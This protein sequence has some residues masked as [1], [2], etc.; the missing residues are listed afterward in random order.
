VL[1][2]EESSPYL[3]PKELKERKN[4]ALSGKQTKDKQ[5][6]RRLLD[7]S[8]KNA[9]LNFLPEKSVHLAVISPDKLYETLEN[10]EEFTLAGVNPD[11]EKVTVNRVKF[12]ANAETRNLKD[13][14]A[15]ENSSGVIRTFSRLGEMN[16]T[17]AR[18]IRKN[19]ES[20]EE[21]GAKILYLAFG[22][23]KWF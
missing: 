18:L 12:G 23:L 13:L 1:G 3:A 14:I 9:L 22:F 17:L 20:D 2:E 19:K 16:E 8:L 11:F 15:L 6:E 5:W 4:L 7:L 21:A 10:G